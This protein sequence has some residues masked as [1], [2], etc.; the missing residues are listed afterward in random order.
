MTT[1]WVI[2]RIG[3]GG[4]THIGFTWTHLDSLGFTWTH[5]DSL[6]LTRE[7][8][9]APATKGKRESPTGGK[10]EKGKVPTP[11]FDPVLTWQRDCARTHARHETIS[12]LDSPPQPPICCL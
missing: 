5:L 7:K 12:R 2:R 6:R 9:K 1:L 4:R 3:G 10:R 11:K 8:G